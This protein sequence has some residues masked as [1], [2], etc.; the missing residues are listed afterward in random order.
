ME[1]FSNSVKEMK[2]KG[3]DYTGKDGKRI[4]SGKLENLR[5]LVN[6]HI[7][8]LDFE[9]DVPTE[10]GPRYVVQ[11]Q[12]DDGS[13]GKYLTNDSEQKF[14]LN[15]FKEDGKIPFDCHITPEYFGQGKVKY[16]FT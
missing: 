16:K 13:I 6:M 1:S 2:Q 15:K 11:F 5:S 10:N 8:V 14:W 12:K 4:L 3:V 7:V 9:P